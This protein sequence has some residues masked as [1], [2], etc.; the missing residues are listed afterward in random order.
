M[1]TDERSAQDW[2]GMWSIANERA[3]AAEAQVAAMHDLLTRILWL[4]PHMNCVCGREKPRI[5]EA[6]RAEA[7]AVARR[8]AGLED[9]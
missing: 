7:R 5:P 3:N 6:L 2:A 8:A 1:T 4:Y 9:A